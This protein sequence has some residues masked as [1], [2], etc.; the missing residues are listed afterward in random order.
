MMIMNAKK[1]PALNGVVL[2]TFFLFM[3][4]TIFTMNTWSHRGA[5][6][7]V[8]LQKNGSLLT[9]EQASFTTLTNRRDQIDSLEKQIAY[10]RKNIMIVQDLMTKDYPHVRESMSKYK[11]DY[12]N[13]LDENL[14]LF[15]LSLKQASQL[16][17]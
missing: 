17:E 2:I 6:P 8:E 14:N 15:R 9:G 3:V 11:L 5:D 16:V 13:V 10:L 7:A 12:I 1:S 4:T